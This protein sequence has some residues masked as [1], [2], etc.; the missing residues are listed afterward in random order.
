MIA[1]VTTTRFEGAHHAALVA[2]SERV[3]AKTTPE[4]L[5]RMI[6]LLPEYAALTGPSAG[7]GNCPDCGSAGDSNVKEHLN[8]P[9]Q[10]AGGQS[11]Q[12]RNVG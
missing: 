7:E 1:Q 11:E 9:P 3:G 2:F 4:T 6:E 5:R 12:R 10:I 8:N